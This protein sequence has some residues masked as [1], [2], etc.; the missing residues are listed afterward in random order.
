MLTQNLWSFIIDSSTQ[1]KGFPMT[2]LLKDNDKLRNEMRPVIR[3]YVHI[4]NYS[5][6]SD[7][8]KDHLENLIAQL[9]G[10]Q[11]F[12]MQ[13]FNELICFDEFVLGVCMGYI[14]PEEMKLDL[15][16]RII[17]VVWDELNKWVIS[18][19]ALEIESKVR[20]EGA[21]LHE[22]LWSQE[23]SARADDHNKSI[24]IHVRCNHD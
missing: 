16:E 12:N 8:A 17:D 24:H 11:S 22:I 13:L 5:D 19:Y 23:M 6:L 20:Q 7:F 14:T 9:L 3:G 18:E 10:C 2:H 21:E 1:P 4:Y 15:M